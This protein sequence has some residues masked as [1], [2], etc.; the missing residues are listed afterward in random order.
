MKHALLAFAIALIATAPA[1]AQYD[2]WSGRGTVGGSGVVEISRA[3]EVM[4]MEVEI[5]ARGGGVKAA[6]A[7]LQTKL[8]A[9]R[10]QLAA[11][12]AID[13]SIAIGEPRISTQQSQQQQQIEQMIASRLRSTGRRREKK[14]VPRPITV[15]ATVTAEWKLPAGDSAELLVAAHELQ[16][17]IRAAKLAGE[18]EESSLTPEEQE[19]LEESGGMFGYNDSNEPKLGEPTF[20]YLTLISDVEH[21]QAM[22]EAFQ[23]ARAQATQLATATGGALGKLE[24]VSTNSQPGLDQDDYGYQYNSAHYRAY[25]RLSRSQQG[26]GGDEPKEAVGLQPGKV[27]YRVQVSA[28]FGLKE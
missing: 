24:S 18:E 9:G 11:L 16:E 2:V 20:T 14:D 8:D 15:I 26:Q 13:D 25:Q 7:S 1:P 5:P 22:A 3:P 4:R 23:K 17:R 10:A 19:I 27:V 21:A 28:G 6:L 12:G